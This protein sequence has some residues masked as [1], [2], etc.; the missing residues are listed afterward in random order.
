MTTTHPH[1]QPT[2]TERRRGRPAGFAPHELIAAARALGPDR[3]ALRDLADALGV[4]RT[5]V[6]NHVRSPDEVGRLV[7]ASLMTEELATSA[8]MPH[9]RASWR[10]W[11]D[12]YA[13]HVRTAVLDTGAWL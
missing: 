5:T 13:V 11:L 4:P 1:G 2:P 12:A 8:W 10:T 9:P 6:Y 7:L 3:L